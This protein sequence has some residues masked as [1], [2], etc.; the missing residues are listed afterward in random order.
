M[1]CPDFLDTNVLVHAFTPESE[2]RRSA[3][4]LLSSKPWVSVQGLNELVNVLRRKRAL[5]WPAVNLVVSTVAQ[6]CAVHP[7]GLET[8]I[9]ARQLAER[10][11]LSWWDAL[12]LAAALQAG[13]T[14]FWS[15]DVQ[16][17]L[18]VE[19]RLRVCNPFWIDPG[20]ARTA[21][22]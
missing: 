15:E 12:Q 2:K 13:A 22:H 6:L 4:A 9:R 11:P 16:H 19:Q 21:S 3:E 18:L 1:T 5:T 17:G 10:Y 20:A 7:Q 14:S 8:H